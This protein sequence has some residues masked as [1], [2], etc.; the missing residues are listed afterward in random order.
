MI[1]SQAFSPV[2]VAVLGFA[3]LVRT[4]DERRI[5]WPVWIALV[6]PTPF[7]LIYRPILHNF[8]AWT[9][10]PPE[11]QASPYKIVSFYGEFLSSVSV[12]LLVGLVIAL[13]IQRLSGVNSNNVGIAARKHEIALV[14]GLL[15]L[16]IFI[17]L[18]LMRNGGA[19][20]PRYCIA[21]AIGFSL[22]FVHTLAKLT[23]AS[24]AAAAIVSSVIL[25][26]IVFGIALQ[27]VHPA[28]RTIV[29]EV[30]LNV[31]DP[32]LPI[33][34]ASGLTFVEMNKREQPEILSRVYYLTDREAALR[35]AHATI[36]EGFGI[37]HEYWPIRDKVMPYHDFVSKNTHFFV[38]GT[39]GYPED[40]LIPKL[41]NDGAKL[42]FVG[43]LAGTYK[44]HMVFE[45][46]M[47]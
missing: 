17:N 47:P 6:V 31:L 4:L 45:V 18:I 15:C 9:A 13:L 40:W 29:K 22:I 23:H 7:V 10:L 46:R 5:D 2:L 42:D 21:T 25:T 3:E 19:F 35:Y 36:F 34:D 11:F 16:P 30:N 27:I 38:L 37:L 32:H 43:E 24:K 12:V 1:V 44:D 14:W 39:P 8:Q 28:G 26:G 33:V 20:W 41:M